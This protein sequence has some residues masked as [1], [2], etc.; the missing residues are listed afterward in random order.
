MKTKDLLS[1]LSRIECSL[2][3]FSYEELSAAEASHLKRSFV[4]FKKQLEDRI[5]QP[6]PSVEVKSLNDYADDVKEVDKHNSDQESN[7]ANLLIAQVSHEIR[8]PLNGIIGF[9]DLLREDDLTK[10]QRERVNAIQTASYA[11]MDIINELL[12]YSK[13]SAGLE[14]F[15]VVDFNLKNLVN[16]VMYLCNTLLTKKGVCLEATIDP[17]IPQLLVGDPSK[18]SQVLLNLLGNSIKFVEKGSIKLAI[19][20]KEQKESQYHLEFI[21]TDTG[22]GISEEN[23]EHIF[24]SFKQADNDTYVRYGGTGLGLSIVK[25]IIEKQNG[26]IAVE[27]K[28][29]QGTTFRFSLPYTKGSLK[30][31]VN[32]NENLSNEE[33]LKT[34]KDLSILVFEDNTL[35]QKLIE[36]RL[37]SWGCKVYLTDNGLYGLNV[38]ENHNVDVVLMDLKMPKM[39]GF[40]ITEC[41]RKN[42]NKRIA[43]L[44]IIALTADFSISDQE[45]CKSQGINDFILKPYTPD[46]LL[47][48]VVKNKKHMKTTMKVASK[49]I[50]P[51]MIVYSDATKINLSLILEEC[52]G[53]M[54]LLEELVMLYKQNA[55]EFMGVLK[56]HLPAGD[57]EKI[58]G[59]AHK[60]KSGLAMMQSESLHS[61]AVQIHKIAKTDGDQKHLQFLFNCF[62]R[63]YPLVEKAIEEQIQALK[64]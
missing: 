3:D 48:K 32:A 50:N 15:E 58:E 64:K 37:K 17:K 44:P 43:N 55:L 34:I 35:N 57:M 28:K 46:E 41:I 38:L 8:T 47:S 54:D 53:K 4:A 42:E 51:E 33:Q 59:A 62:V 40:E 18:L 27:S 21:V 13:L 12:E 36:Q 61:I 24:K 39:S 7:D 26:T 23:L 19:S 52:M 29:G 10:L 2:D 9:S 25:Q 5:F 49:A 22:I 45:K 30:S 6:I 60:I 20:L 1:Q 63:E 56:A 14:Q 11:L 31:L 16:D